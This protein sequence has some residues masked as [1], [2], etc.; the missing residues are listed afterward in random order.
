MHQEVIHVDIDKIIVGPYQPRDTSPSKDLNLEGLA[1][2]IR[3]VGILQPPVVRRCRDGL[4]ELIAGERRLRAAKLAGWETIPVILKESDSLQ[5]ALATLI[6]NIQRVDLN[7][8]ESARA[9]QKIKDEFLLTQ[10]ELAE[11]VGLKRSTLTNLLRLLTLSCDIQELITRGSLSLGH[12]KVLL[13]VKDPEHRERLAQIILRNRL[14]VRESERKAL[15]VSREKHPSSLP[16]ETKRNIFLEQIR[17]RLE[18]IYGTKVIIEGNQQT[19]KIS[20]QYYD[21]S[22]LNRL[23]NRLGYSEEE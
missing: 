16:S 13:S 5:S 6:E 10:E 15:P 1:D 20:L 18:K 9:L 3:H 4:Y 23:L 12:A 8:M 7:V 17:E 21:L 19:G 2:T 11:K 14:S 22:D